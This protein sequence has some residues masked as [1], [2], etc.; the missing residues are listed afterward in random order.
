MLSE[1]PFT[2]PPYSYLSGPYWYQFITIHN[3]S[4]GDN[5]ARNN[6]IANK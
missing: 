2:E 5:I 4:K 1:I 6:R 3:V